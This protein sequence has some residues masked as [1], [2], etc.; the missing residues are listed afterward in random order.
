M[1]SLFIEIPLE[2]PETIFKTPFFFNAL[3]WSSAAFGDLKPKTLAI[4]DLV[5]G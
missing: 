2:A 4:S 1:S 3:R 5:G